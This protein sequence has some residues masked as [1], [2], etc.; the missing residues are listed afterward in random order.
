MSQTTA[1]KKM[2]S[3]S[4]EIAFNV[5]MTLGHASAAFA[6]YQSGRFT[7]DEIAKELDQTP[8]Q[9]AKWISMLKAVR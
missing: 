1:N 3:E 9:I 6:L 4:E 7:I 5:R 2:I 8:H